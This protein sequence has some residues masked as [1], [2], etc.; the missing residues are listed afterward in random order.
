MKVAYVC[1]DPGVPVFGTKGA[2][3]HVREV[4]RVLVAGGARVDLFCRRTGGLPPPDLAGVRV[5]RLPAVASRDVAGRELEMLAQ[6][7]DVERMLAAAGAFDLVYERYSL[8]DAAAMS[9]ARTAGVPAVL[10]VNAP[11]VDEQAEHRG[12]VHRDEALTVLRAAAMCSS[13]VACVS[14]PVADWVRSV[15]GPAA[16]VVV[17]PNG[18]DVERVRPG[19]GRGRRPY[20]VGFVGTLKPWHGVD[21]LVAAFA[22]LAHECPDARLLVVGD[23]PEAPALRAGV[24]QAGLDGA[25]EFT[26]AVEPDAVPALLHRMDVATAPYPAGASQYFSPLK[27]YEYLAAALP[28]V[29]SRTGQLPSILRDG[30]DGV[31]VP[32]GDPAALARELIR[33]R[34]DPGRRLRLAR[35]ARATAERHHTWQAVV[36]RTLAA[37]GVELPVPAVA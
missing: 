26:G 16:P 21:V 36:G 20:T 12:L 2:S 9:W 3:V 6:G 10:E 8:W 1:A 30:V 15:A 11:L 19:L 24:R 22:M 5:H 23:G 32:P 27:V 35:A 7:R 37:A 13:V 31:L 17:Q 18:V 33:L 25:V 14:E 28:V 34:H 4:L 29:A